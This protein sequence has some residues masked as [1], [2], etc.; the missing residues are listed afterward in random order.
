MRGET[1]SAADRLGLLIHGSRVSRMIRVVATLGLADL[2]ADGPQTAEELASATACDAP[3][4]YR[5]LRA[6]ASIGVFARGADRR[7]ALTPLSQLL[8][9][10]APDSFR[11]LALHATAGEEHDI[12]EDLL[13][14]LRTGEPAFP[15][16]YGAGFFDYLASHPQSAAAFNARMTGRVRAVAAAVARAYDFSASR[17]VLDVGGGHGAVLRA[18]LTEHPHLRGILFDLPEVVAGARSALAAA[19]LAA[20]CARVGGSFFDR[21][22][23]GADTAILCDILHDWDDHQ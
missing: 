5:L 19:G 18:V 22:P 12:W 20:R 6:L 14:A 2:L 1:T 13:Y 4:L 16:R 7:F 9:D 10:G 21:L 23:A 17:L 15:H 11:P 8:R 3:S